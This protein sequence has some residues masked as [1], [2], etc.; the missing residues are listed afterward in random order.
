[1]RVESW[2][3][4]LIQYK[5]QNMATTT[6]KMGMVMLPKSFMET[7][8]SLFPKNLLL[9]AVMQSNSKN[10]NTTQVSTKVPSIT[11]QPVTEV[12]ATPVII[13]KVML[14]HLYIPTATMTL[15]M[16]NASKKYCKDQNEQ[17]QSVTTMFLNCPI[18]T[19]N[20][21]R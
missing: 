3:E 9:K 6:S 12:V 4:S 8:V 10:G 2:V 14:T 17:L 5:Y 11:V 19:C 18:P 13:K 16:S 15:L 1:M 7:E 20:L 21:G